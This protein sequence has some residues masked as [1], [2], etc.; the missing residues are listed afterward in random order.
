MIPP[1][2]SEFSTGCAW[3]TFTGRCP[4]QMPKSSQLAP[5]EC[6][7][8]AVQ[9]LAPHPISDPL[10]PFDSLVISFLWSLPKAHD[11]RWGLECSSTSKLS[12]AF[13]LSS[14]FATTVQYSFRI[15]ADVIYSSI[16]HSIFHSWKVWLRSL[17]ASIS[18]P[19]SRGLFPTSQGRLG[20]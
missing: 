9:L 10:P 11:H 2:C 3:N 13:R 6:S 15:S 17:S 19:T 12:V 16:S 14:L 8:A 18:T 20:T 7:E 5:F 1:G 4:N